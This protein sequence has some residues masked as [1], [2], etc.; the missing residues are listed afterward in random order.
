[1]PTQP[2]ARKVYPRRNARL[3]YRPDREVTQPG[4]EP[5]AT[6]ALDAKEASPVAVEA[7][8]DSRG[9]A[10]DAEASV[11]E[12]TADEIKPISPR[13]PPP[14]SQSKNEEPESRCPRCA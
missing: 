1:M 5:L 3:E 9:S 10:P 13:S 7:S 4:D 2:D 8:P 12:A 6:A 11:T 14:A